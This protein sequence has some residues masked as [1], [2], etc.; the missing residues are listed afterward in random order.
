[1]SIMLD[2]AISNFN[3]RKRNKMNKQDRQKTTE[4]DFNSVVF[5]LCKND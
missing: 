4:S 5:Y 3:F 2:I 1:M